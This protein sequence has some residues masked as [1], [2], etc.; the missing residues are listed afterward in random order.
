MTI[1]ENNKLIAE[2]MGFPKEERSRPKEGLSSTIYGIPE[3]I[4]QHQSLTEFWGSSVKDKN[5]EY[6]YAESAEFFLFHESFDWLMP[7][8]LRILSAEFCFECAHKNIHPWHDA[9]DE[10]NGIKIA[11]ERGIEPL[12]EAVVAFLTWYNEQ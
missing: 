3:S 9:K 7:V 10:I 4:S 6:L 12:Y 11:L 1:T 5:G 2:F 8:A